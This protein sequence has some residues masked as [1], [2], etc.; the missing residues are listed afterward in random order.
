VG[1]AVLPEAGL[2]PLFASVFGAP[3]LDE[4]PLDTLLASFLEAPE[5]DGGPLGA[6]VL[7]EEPLDATGAPGA[8]FALT[9][10]AGCL[11]FPDGKP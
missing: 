9:S 6:A 11:T 3:E 10:L 1:V 8:G 7:P 5:L 2:A 4:G